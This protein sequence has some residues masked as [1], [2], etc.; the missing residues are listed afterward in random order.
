MIILL[1]RFV[2]DGLKFDPECIINLSLEDIGIK[3][4]A[5]KRKRL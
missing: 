3:S 1:E 2:Y 5:F 4:T